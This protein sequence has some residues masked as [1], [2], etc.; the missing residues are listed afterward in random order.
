MFERLFK[1]R[2]NNTSVRRETIAGITTF[3]TMVY[4]VFVNP[5]M[6]A[7]AGMDQGAAFVATCIA[8]AIGCFI[9][10][11]WANYPLALAPGM[12]LNAFFTYGVVLGMGYSWQAA[13]GAVFMSGCIFLCLSLFKVREWIIDAI[14][15]VLK[16]AIATGIGA[17]LALIALKNAG[18][19]VASPAT[20]VQLGDITAPG[21]LL[22][23]LSFFVIA[24]LLYR[25]M[26]SGV[27]ISILLVTGIALGL[28]LV[29]YKG[30][31]SMPPSIAPTFM[32]LDFAAALEISMLTVIFAFLFVDLFDTSGTLVAVTQKAGLADEQGKMPRLGR[33]LSAD[34]TATIAGSMLGTST[35]TSYIESVAGVSVGGRTGLTAVVVGICFLLMMFFAPLAS[36]IPAYATAGAILYVAVLM[37]QNLKLVNWDD[38]TDAIPVSVVLLMTPLTFSIAHGIALGFIAYTAVKLVCG[39]KDEISVS[40]WVLT[41]LFIIKFAF[42]S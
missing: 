14:P 38:M 4:I 6:L 29:E 10:G 18:I 39:K 20:L 40:V 8:A 33:A 11:L 21:P 16:R 22:A 32:Q 25:D 26:K 3:I 1:I 27:L 41:A 36:M 15:L 35:T 24:A 7:E 5:A 37:M 2:E 12:G 34:S 19:I 31:V 13:L 28:D 17:F 23:I 9:M 42:L 30:I